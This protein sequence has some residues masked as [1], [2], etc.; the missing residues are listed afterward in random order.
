MGLFDF[1][2][3]EQ[4]AKCVLTDSGTVQ[5]ECCLF[6]V[7]NVTIRDVTERPE[8]LEVGSNVISGAEPDSIIRCV[9]IALNCDTDWAPPLEYLANNVR[10]GDE[11]N[12]PSRRIDL[13]R[14]CS[15]SGH[16]S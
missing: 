9:E 14:I 4:R 7:P 11:I 16:K 5:E 1:I 2:N 8:T 12:F 6:A 13:G 15:I 10:N 3:L